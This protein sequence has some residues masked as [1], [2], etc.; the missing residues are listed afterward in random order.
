MK[1]LRYLRSFTAEQVFPQ[2]G[3]PSA[4]ES[5]ADSI[6]IAVKKVF[7]GAE[8][9]FFALFQAGNVFLD[10]SI[11]DDRLVTGSRRRQ[12]HAMHHVDRAGMH[13]R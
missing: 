9:G 3:L 7:A 12:D 5:V 6:E 8:G 2:D 1:C 13:E 10:C 4:V 11:S